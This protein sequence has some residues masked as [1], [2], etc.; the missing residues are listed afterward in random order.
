MSSRDNRGYS[1]FPAQYLETTV[2]L[3]QMLDKPVF[4]DGRYVWL[5]N[6]PLWREPPIRVKKQC[7]VWTNYV[8]KNGLNDKILVCGDEVRSDTL[9][10]S[11]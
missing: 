6:N 2:D 5:A 11:L 10:R 1:Q 8:V 9:G 3:Q 7:V 4:M